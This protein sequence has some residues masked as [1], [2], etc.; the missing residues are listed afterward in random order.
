MSCL[1]CHLWVLTRYSCKIMQICTWQNWCWNPWR[2]L[3][4]HDLSG[5]PAAQTQTQWT[6]LGWAKQTHLSSYTPGKFP[7]CVE[8]CLAERMGSC[9]ARSDLCWL[10]A[11]QA[12]Y[13][14]WFGPVEAIHVI[15]VISYYHYHLISQDQF[16]TCTKYSIF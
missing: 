11:C 6:Y 16:G 3:K 12:S 7:E 9:A 4:L 2:K 13:K 1:T 8:K 5:Q 10:I 14:P 15:R